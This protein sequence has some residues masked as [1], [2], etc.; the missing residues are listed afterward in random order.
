MHQRFAERL[1]HRKLPDN[2][3]SHAPVH[4][5]VFIQFAVSA[6]F[7]QPADPLQRL[8]HRDD[9]Q[10]RIHLAEY[11]VQ[12]DPGI[13]NLPRVAE[14]P[15]RLRKDIFHHILSRRSSFDHNQETAGPLI[16]D[17]SARERFP[18]IPADL[19]QHMIDLNSAVDL[20]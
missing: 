2:R 15:D 14:S 7:Q 18:Q 9:L 19:I 4:D 3:I 20:T 8:V 10:I 17:R 16:E 5:K 1:L 6:L 12:V 11:K 13:L